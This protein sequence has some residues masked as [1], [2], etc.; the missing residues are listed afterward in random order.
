VAGL[1][2]SSTFA[3]SATLNASD[4]VINVQRR[5][6]EGYLTVGNNGTESAGPWL[7]SAGASIATF[8]LI[9]DQTTVGYS[10]AW[11][12]REYYSLSVSHRHQWVNG[13]SLSAA[14]NFSESKKPGTVFAKLF[15]H[16]TKSD[17]FSLKVGYP[18]IRTRNRNLSLGLVYTQRDSR[19]ELLGSPFTEDKIRSLAFDANFDFSDELGGVTQIIP[20]VTVGLDA[21]D[22]TDRDPLSS[23]PMAPASYSR[24]NLYVSRNQSLPLG[25]SLFASLEIQLAGTIL[26]SYE[27]FSLGGQLFGKGYE[28]GALEGDNGFGGSLEL[29]IP[30][31]LS[32][33]TIMPYAFV[34]GGT[35]WTKG[36]IAGVDPHSELSS[37]GLGLRLYGQPEGLPVSSFSLNVFCAKPLKTVDRQS[38]ARWVALLS[39]NY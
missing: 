30:L 36:R 9:G 21:L 11:D 10:Q 15:D 13:F 19:A 26:P 29:R 12:W 4:I 34:D 31:S 32:E 6:L 33:L 2:V 1:T 35:V 37:A 25:L 16:A 5:I 22:A 17:T 38:S 39:F 3:K 28:S 20:S 24:A 27:Q 23:S 8:P 18:L 7:I 14:Y